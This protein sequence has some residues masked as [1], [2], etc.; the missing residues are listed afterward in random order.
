MHEM[1]AERAH[2]DP[3]KVGIAAWDGDLTFQQ[4]DQHSTR[5]AHELR[6]LGVQLHD[7]VP[8]CFEKSRWTVVAVLAAMKAGATFVLM[9]P[10]LPLA[11]LQNMASQ[12]RARTMIS[13]RKQRDFS[14]EIL[15]NGNF[16]VVEEA[17]FQN[18]SG[19]ELPELLTVPASTL[20]YLIF[21]SGSTG[22]PKGVKISHQTYTSSAIPRAKGVGYNKN[23][24]VLDF[25]SYAFD[26]SIDSML[27]TLGNGGCL[28]IPSDEDRMN[29]INEVIRK[30]RINYAGITPSVARILDP[31]VID[32]LEI[33]G[34]GGEAASARDVNHWGKH[35]RIVIGY[36]PCECTIGCTINSDTATGRDYISIGHG[37]GAN[38]W[39]VDPNDHEKLMPV[40][41]VGEILIEGPIVGQGYLDDPE[42]TA[43]AFIK[44][45]QWLVAGHKEYK[46]R[47]GRLYKSG[48]LGKYDPDG[49][50]DIV[51]AGRKDTQ[52]KLRG[53]RVELGEI[54]S[55]LKARLPSETHVVV[56]VIVPQGLGA[57]P[58]LVAFIAAETTRTHAVT[59]LT[60]AK[61]PADLQD[62]LAGMNSD[63]SKVLPRYM[64]PTAYIPV[65][66]IPILIS[67]KVDRKRLKAY[68]NTV[69][70]RD[71][72]Q[73]AKSQFAREMNEIE[74]K[75][76]QAWSN[77]LKVPVEVIGLDDNFFALG[78]DSLAAMRLVTACRSEGI[79]LTVA[80]AFNNP[81]LS[82]MAQT[83]RT[84]QAQERTEVKPFSMVSM[85]AEDAR[86]EA[87]QACGVDV[88][89]VEDVYPCTASQESLFTLSLRSDEAYIAQRVASIPPHIDIDTWKTAWQKVA[90]SLPILRTHVAQLSEPGLQQVVLKENILWRQA[91]DLQEY[92]TTD[93]AEKMQ[94]GQSLA[95][96]AIIDDV[97]CGQRYMVWTVHHVL[98]DGWSEP[99]IL[100]EVTNSLQGETV[101]VQAHMRDYVRYMCDTD[102]EAM[103]EYWRKEL[104]GANGPQ[105]PKLPSRDYLP[106]PNGM[107]DKTISLP[108]ISGSAFTL[109][110]LLRG[111]WALVASQYTNSNDV[112]FGETLTGR[113][114]PVAGVEGIVGPLIATV[115]VRIQIDRNSSIESY[116]RDVQ[117]T[118]L[119]RT[120]YQHMGWQNI[121]K[122]SSD[123]QFASEAGTGLVIQ[124]DPEYVGS[125]LGFEQGDVVR[126]AL[127]FNPY[128]LMV[129]FGIKGDM[130]RA[131]ASF[132]TSLIAVSQMERV[133]DQLEA[134]CQRLV[135]DLSGKLGDVPCLSEAELDQIWAQNRIA[136]LT[137]DV[138]SGTVRA[139]ASTNAGSIYPPAVV[140]WVCDAHNPDILAAF[141]TVGELWLEG[142]CLSGNLV[143]SPLWLLA[144]SKSH[145]G[146]SGK[147]QATGDLVQLQE[148][149]TII[150]VGRK[151]NSQPVNG[152]TVDINELESHLAKHLSTEA[153]SAVAFVP[154][155]GEGGGGDSR[156]IVFIE[157]KPSE[158]A[159][160][161]IHTEPSNEKI[162][163]KITPDLAASVKKFEKFVHDSMPSYMAPFAYIFVKDMP[164]ALGQADR[165]ALK[166]LASSISLDV[167][168]KLRLSLEAALSQTSTASTITA[169]EEV[170]RSAWSN[171]LGVPIEHIDIDDNFFRLGGDSVLAMKL[172]ANLRGQGYGLTVA[173]I[174]RHMRLSDAAKV[175]TV[176]EVTKETAPSYKAFSI[177][178]VPSNGI[179]TF[180]AGEVY[181]KLADSQWAVKD[182]CPVTDSQALDVKATINAPRTSYQYT[183]LFMDR[184]IDVDK[185]L[186]S[187]NELVK[188]HDILRTV[189]IAHESSLLQV[190]LE[191][192]TVPVTLK[193]TSDPDLEAFVRNVCELRAE[194][195]FEL[196]KPFVEFTHVEGVEGKH[197]LVIG[198]SHAQYDGV[199]L[200]NL[201]R[202]LECL[203][204]GGEMQTSQPFSHYISRTLDS[205]VQD[206]SKEYW[207]SLLKDS[208]MSTLVGDTT[209][210]TDKAIFQHKP[211]EISEKPKEITTAN[212]LTA[213]WA[214]VLARRLQKRDVTFGSITSG[215]N[216]GDAFLEDVQGPCYQFTPVRVPFQEGWTALDLLHFVQKQAAESAPHD[217]IGFSAIRESCTNWSDDTFFD[218][219]VHHQDWEDFDS[220]PFAGSTCKV[221]VVN[222]HGDAAKPLKVV[223]FVKDGEVRV[224]VVGSEREV[225]FVDK[226]LEELVICVEELARGRDVSIVC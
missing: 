163:S 212:L 15:E 107:V 159:T 57:Q 202:D 24:R 124:P 200:P 82:E 28:C 141:G 125:E 136:P 127:H 149:G 118:M 180:L 9:D 216:M 207:S 150:F 223:S 86:S 162:A 195:S 197:A 101:E 173:D 7:F 213:A 201:L 185:L 208:S 206:K 100:R 31:D 222:P 164:L 11:R 135:N 52:V 25:A 55:Q 178:D 194:E 61:L 44:D 128:P 80:N 35:T 226:V 56:E 204:A 221:D 210:P 84:T 39:I 32:S 1:V 203:Y 20:M 51:F 122:V 77:T 137:Q 93:H 169:N 67:G 91:S 17:K 74:R 138:L 184:T 171:I 19:K 68:G 217:S 97:A 42:K 83:V 121:R 43:A 18:E 224:G 12:V 72:D 105:F 98:Y 41:A 199:S 154:V 69:D 30:M 36:G 50:G 219:V 196:G 27:L 114:I 81:T 26:V 214:V 116:L 108:N 175:M 133:I 102:K 115:P 46:G 189:F 143:T 23:S 134:T 198:L 140:S 132:D 158:A 8:I 14:T 156:L 179:K 209:S 96:Y 47:H 188:V 64:V 6:E 131:C 153:K 92:L 161:N 63:L 16:V 151:E 34:L 49:S 119:A 112:V 103:H 21:T 167:Y 148:D 40:G 120:T 38:I 54:E 94:L 146:R 177:I 99:L 215:R 152:H 147:V 29:D 111:A 176:T 66:H 109:A 166:D 144:G 160:V 37:N 71:L 172:A 186:R 13:S 220:M 182:V 85:A 192:L 62:Q 53:Q 139:S 33:L 73:Q 193:K 113:D 76:Q 174:F 190:V 78:G 79:E 211:V 110:T 70:L 170:L 183:M 191:N 90:T 187:C 60:S 2:Q 65:N 4:I 88:G 168:S 123:A 157:Q 58:T 10:S 126:E 218:S 142:D 104:D 89:S 145:S 181:P 106:T 22:T 75:L 225:V 59:D 129:A 117:Q 155:S 3:H 48:D 5:I 87:A 205:K 165:A 95:R 130:L 45:P